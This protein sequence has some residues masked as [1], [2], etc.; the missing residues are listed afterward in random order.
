[1]AKGE[2]AGT[3]TRAFLTDG[4]SWWP[5]GAWQECCVTHEIAYWCGG[6]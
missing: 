4:C 1:M 2:P 5:D 6:P 3:P